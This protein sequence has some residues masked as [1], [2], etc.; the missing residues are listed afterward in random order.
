MADKVWMIKD[1]EEGMNKWTVHVMV[2]EKGYP[3]VTA[4]QSVYQ[5]VVL[6]DSEVSIVV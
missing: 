2:L 4:M 5:K 1:L 3:R 6:I